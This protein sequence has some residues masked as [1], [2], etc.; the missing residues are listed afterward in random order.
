MEAGWQCSQSQVMRHEQRPA[1]L[2]C[3]RKQFIQSCYCYFSEVI[4]YFTLLHCRKV[5]DYSTLLLKKVICYCNRITYNMLLP[6]ADKHSSNCQP[7]YKTL[8]SIIEATVSHSGARLTQLCVTLAPTYR[9]LLQ[10]RTPGNRHALRKNIYATYN[11]QF[12]LVQV[13]VE[14]P[15][16]AFRSEILDVGTIRG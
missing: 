8:M 7:R 10:R 15:K 9:Y 11:L 6:N 5:I 3:N 12:W 13:Q 16:I 2:E 1:R 14:K 4:N